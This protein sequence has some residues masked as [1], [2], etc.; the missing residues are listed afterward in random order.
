MHQQDYN[1]YV[2]KRFGMEDCRPVDTPF[3][4]HRRLCY[5]TLYSAR[6]GL[7]SQA[8]Q[9]ERSVSSANADRFKK[10]KKKKSTIIILIT[11]KDLYIQN[12]YTRAVL[13]AKTQLRY[14]P[15]GRG[16]KMSLL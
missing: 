15:V 13:T 16:D 12:H 8:V 3:D 2:L 5:L 14:N 6:I 9:G 4:P 10:K 7:S 1:R 11:Y